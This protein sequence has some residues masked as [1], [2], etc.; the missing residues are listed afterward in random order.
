MARRSGRRA[1]RLRRALDDREGVES[2]PGAD[3]FVAPGPAA[4]EMQTGAAGVSGDARGDVQQAVAEPFWFP[5]ARGCIGEQEP[6]CPG[7]HVL[8]H[9]HQ[10]QPDSVRLESA[11]RQ[12]AQALSL[13]QRIA[14]S[15]L[16]RWRWICSS[17][18]IREPV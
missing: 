16:A 7:D 15:T 12:V 1:G 5:A 11:E 18:A 2:L 17:R 9:E 4:W 6:L 14:S 10:L 13:A 8:A 3:E